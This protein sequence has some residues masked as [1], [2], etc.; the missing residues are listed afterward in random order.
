MWVRF[1]D[2]FWF[3]YSP[4]VKKRYPA[5]TVAQVTTRCG[6]AAI[7]QDKAVRMK[8]GKRGAEPVEVTD[9]EATNSG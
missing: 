2:E 4:Y 6:E 9:G 5:G 8:K 7:A 3:R 1:T